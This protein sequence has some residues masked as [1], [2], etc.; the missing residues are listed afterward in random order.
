MKKALMTFAIS[1]VLALM[2]PLMAR[3]DLLETLIDPT[4]IHMGPEAGIF[5]FDVNIENIPFILDSD[6]FDFFQGDGN[7]LGDS[8]T[9]KMAYMDAG[10]TRMYSASLTELEMVKKVI[11]PNTMLLLGSCLLGLGLFTIKFRK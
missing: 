2:Q 6:H 5:S 11:E 3:A 8:S 7:G 4:I 10:N 9:I 1:I